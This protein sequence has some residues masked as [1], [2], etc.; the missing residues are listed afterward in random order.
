MDHFGSRKSVGFVIP[1]YA[2]CSYKATAS[3]ADLSRFKDSRLDDLNL[4]DVCGIVFVFID[5][6]D[7]S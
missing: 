4:I 7:I 6:H 1:I 3:A 2:I 5:A